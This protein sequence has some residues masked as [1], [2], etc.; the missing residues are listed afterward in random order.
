MKA[1][2]TVRNNTLRLME[3]MQQYG[4]DQSSKYLIPTADTRVILGNILRAKEQLLD[5]L[6]SLQYVRPDFELGPP[7]QQYFPNVDLSEE[8]LRRS[9]RR[10]TL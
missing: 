2:Q 5:A 8:L 4:I 6:S 1:F 3:Y 7:L 10:I 9:Q